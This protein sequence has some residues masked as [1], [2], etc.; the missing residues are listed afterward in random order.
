[1]APQL[2]DRRIVMRGSHYHRRRREMDTSVAEGATHD[3][4]P[5]AVVFLVHGTWAFGLRKSVVSHFLGKDFPP[6]NESIWSDCPGDQRPTGT[7]NYRVGKHAAF[8]RRLSKQLPS[9]TR[10]RGFRW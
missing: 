10:I 8:R 2:L 6:E 5:A 4:G 9:G 3:I 1:M 7:D